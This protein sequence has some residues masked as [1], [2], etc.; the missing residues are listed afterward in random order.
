MRS[1]LNM[2]FWL[3]WKLTR[4]LFRSRRTTDRLRVLGWLSRALMLLFTVPVFVLMGAG[5]AV[6]LILLTPAAAYEVAMLAN[7]GMFFLWLLLPASYNSQLIERF[8]MS[9]LFAYPVRFSSIVVGS[10]LMSLLT[11]TGLATLPILVGEIVGLAWHQ[12]LALP[13][14]L[15][16][17]LP[18][19]AVLALSG[20]IMDDFFD[21]VAGDRRLRALVLSLFSLPFI[22]CWAGQYVVQLATDNYQRLPLVTQI[23]L[24]QGLEAL[25]TASNPSEFLE[26]LRPSRLLVWLPPGWGTAGMGLAVVGPTLGSEWGRQL[27]FLGASVASVALLLWVHAGITRRLIKGAALHVGTQRVRTRRWRLVLFGAPTFWAL[28]H[29]DWTY[30]W[31]SPMPRRLIFS[32]AISMLAMAV[33]LWSKPSSSLSKVLPLIVSAFGITIVS[34]VVNMG[35]TA[36]YFGVMDREGFGTLALSPP[37]RRQ[38]ILSANLVAL[39]F[40]GVQYLVLLLG[41]AILTRAWM[42]LP[43]GLYLGLCMQAGGSPAYNLAAIMGPYRAQLRSVGG[44]QRGNLWGMLAWAVSAAP[45]LA[46]IVLPYIFW[47]PGL[48]ITLPVGAAYSVGLYLLTLKPLTAMLQRREYDIFEAVTVED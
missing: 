43:L 21:L 2:L 45:V 16:G 46:L 11:M 23:P 7:V 27:L 24:L 31:R 22:L 26:I 6:G 13:L 10:T 44:R 9:R 8:E 36:N 42:V 33:P 48:W 1:E 40:V 35:M 41:V 38:I 37:D 25:G 32:A 47:R 15:A 34:M 5:L 39:L 19:Y 20:R 3:Q 12:P 29:K 14:F 18:V 28:V 17:A 4:S 30:L